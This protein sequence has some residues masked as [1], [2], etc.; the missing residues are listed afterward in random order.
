MLV[1]AL[2]N[3]VNKD[4]EVSLNFQNKLAGFITR[5]YQYN[6]LPSK[7]YFGYKIYW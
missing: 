4:K 1:G 6:L 2:V 3:L 5:L 7:I